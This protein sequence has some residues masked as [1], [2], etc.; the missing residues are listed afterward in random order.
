MIN[1]PILLYIIPLS[2]I[3]GTQSHLCHLLEGYAHQYKI[4][5][6]TGEKG[7]LTEFAESKN[8]DVHILPNLIRSID[9][10]SDFKATKEFIALIKELKPCLIHAHNSKAGLVGRIAGYLCGVPTIYTA[11]G[12]Q[13]ASGTPIVHKSL[14][15]IN[16]KLGAALSSKIICVSESDR[17]LALHS[18]LTDSSKLVTIHLGIEDS[19][20]ITAQPEKQPPKIVMVARFD[21]QKDHFTLLNAISKLSH[22]KFSVDLIGSGPL[23][24]DCVEMATNLDITNKVNF[25]GNRHDVPKILSSAQL[26]VLSTHYEGLPISIL[27]AMRAGLPV[28]ASNVDG[29]PEEVIDGETGLLVKR[30]DIDELAFTIELLVSSP[31][32][33]KSMGELGRQTFQNEFCIDRMLQETQSLYEQLLSTGQKR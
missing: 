23:L 30:Q 29:I 31:N 12:W 19:C 18:S 16:E 22:L 3:G 26:F 21:T 28:I 7:Y 2:V 15:Y 24:S 20:P 6:A 4:H 33:R 10:R 8:I 27:E 13:F 5:L 25:L 11:H 32:I 9:F 17:K 14:S 1:K